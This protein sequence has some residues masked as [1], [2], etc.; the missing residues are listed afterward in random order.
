MGPRRHCGAMRSV[1]LEAT[2]GRKR[3]GSDEPV[4]VGRPREQ[5]SSPVWLVAQQAW[6]ERPRAA[7]ADQTIDPRVWLGASLRSESGELPR[8]ACMVLRRKDCGWWKPPAIWSRRRF[9]WCLADWSACYLESFVLGARA[10]PK[11][12]QAGCSEPI[13]AGGLAAIPAA[14]AWES[15]MQ[16]FPAACEP[17]WSESGNRLH[18][19]RRKAARS[20][21][22][23]F[24]WAP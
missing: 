9:G 7:A 4:A 6:T 15:A 19:L 5:R 18:D 17:D 13:P 3:P 16:L 1:R 23:H 10:C 24:G 21:S 11:V 8:S 14:P 12:V 2:E 22:R 20:Q